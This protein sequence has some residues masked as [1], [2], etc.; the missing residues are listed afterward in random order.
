MT[1]PLESNIV[2]RARFHAT[3]ST[4]ERSAWRRTVEA[5]TGSLPSWAERKPKGQKPT[6]DVAAAVAMY[7]NGGITLRQVGERFGVVPEAIGHHVRKARAAEV[8]A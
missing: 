1:H 4:S 3:T 7:R 6:F 2:E 5:L 8:R